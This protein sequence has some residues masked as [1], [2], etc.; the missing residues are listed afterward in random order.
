MSDSNIAAALT[1][2]LSDY[3]WDKSLTQSAS[4][5]SVAVSTYIEGGPANA[6]CDNTS[7][8]SEREAF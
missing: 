8:G 6:E 1:K 3:A 2:Y 4:A 7:R 5:P